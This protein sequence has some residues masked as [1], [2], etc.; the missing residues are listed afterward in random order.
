MTFRSF[1]I[2]TI[3]YQSRLPRAKVKREKDRI[4]KKKNIQ[5]VYKSPLCLLIHIE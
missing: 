4:I 3:H 1:E 5:L 2:E